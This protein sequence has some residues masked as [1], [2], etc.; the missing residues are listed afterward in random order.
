MKKLLIILVSLMV[1]FKMDA[2]LG[3][4]IVKNHLKAI[5]GVE[6]WNS[7][8]TLYMEV[9]MDMG[10]LQIPVKIWQEHMKGIRVEFT[11]QGLTGIQ[12]ATEK[13]GWSL[14]PFQ[15]Q[16]K[17][18]PTDEELLKNQRSQFNIRGKITEL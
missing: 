7:L 16:D 15:G 6:K 2:Q 11:V 9:V 17:A 5:G 8:N 1:V 18:E 4:K 3:N 12:V 14:M 10:G 13:D